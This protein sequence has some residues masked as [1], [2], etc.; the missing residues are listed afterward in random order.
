MKN[1]VLSTFAILSLSAFSLTG[2]FDLTAN[3][4]DAEASLKETVSDATNNE[5]LAMP[6]G[7]DDRATVE[8]HQNQPGQ[9]M[10]LPNAAEPE[11]VIYLI[12]IPDQ[13]RR[14]SACNLPQ[15]LKKDG[16]KIQFSGEV[17]EIK[18][19]ERWLATPYKLNSVKILQ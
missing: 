18:P 3:A 7:F 2:C 5:I 10:A 11:G 16:M 17:K 12:A 13:N 4:T 15:S 6:C 8:K 1:S 9:I 19:E 14:F